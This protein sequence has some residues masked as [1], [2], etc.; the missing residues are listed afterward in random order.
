[1][2]L[3]SFASCWHTRSL[4]LS[5]FLCNGSIRTGLADGE[6]TASAWGVLP[7]GLGHVG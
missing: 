1:M 3:V 7:I 4:Y 6:S 5:G 2:K